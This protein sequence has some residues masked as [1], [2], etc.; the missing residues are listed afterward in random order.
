MKYSNS[1]EN[2]CDYVQSELTF[3]PLD[4]ADLN[5]ICGGKVGKPIKQIGCNG[6][7]CTC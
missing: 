4:F 1:N 3:E 7:K 5:N 2:V 6:H